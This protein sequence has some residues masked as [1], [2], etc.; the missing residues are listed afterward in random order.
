M[1][2]VSTK[3]QKPAQ[4]YYYA[5][6]RVPTNKLGAFVDAVAEAKAKANLG[7]D[8]I[9]LISIEDGIY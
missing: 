5:Y 4:K 2:T 3:A 6:I 9:K 7:D 8:A 1:S